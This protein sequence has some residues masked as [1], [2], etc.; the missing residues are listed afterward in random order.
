LTKIISIP[1]I[2]NDDLVAIAEQ[3]TAVAKK[4]ISPAMTISLLIAV[5]RAHLSEPCAR[6]TFLQRI[7]NTDFMSPEEFEKTWD[8]PFQKKIKRENKSDIN[9]TG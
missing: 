6:D 8:I 7:A 2:V 9:L 3:L 5:Y 4:P 1:E